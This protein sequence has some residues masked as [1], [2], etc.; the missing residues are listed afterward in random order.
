MIESLEKRYDLKKLASPSK[1]VIMIIVQRRQPMFAGV[2]I[3]K[4][5]SVM[6]TLAGIA[7]APTTQ[8]TIPATSNAVV[9]AAAHGFDMS[10]FG[11]Q[12]DVITASLMS[13]QEASSKAGHLV[14]GEVRDVVSMEYERFRQDLETFDPKRQYLLVVPNPLEFEYRIRNQETVAA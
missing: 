14:L 10:Q 1:P 2:S 12:G 11:Q 7:L 3:N 9:E 13:E 5:W 6:E 4:M 8:R